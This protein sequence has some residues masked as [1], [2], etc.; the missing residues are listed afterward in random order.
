MSADCVGDEAI[1]I[2]N[3][4]HC[5]VIVGSSRIE[6]I[7]ALINQQQCN[8]VICDDGLQD[9]RFIRKAGNCND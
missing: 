5:P 3:R 7:D 8:V 9:Y 6:V 1:L 4:T 2:F